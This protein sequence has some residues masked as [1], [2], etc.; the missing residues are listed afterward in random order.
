MSQ[1]KQF[2]WDNDGRLKNDKCAIELNEKESKNIGD[3]QLSGYDSSYQDYTN[4]LND[5]AH[6]QKTYRNQTHNVD[7]ESALFLA[8]SSNP[9]YINQLF[10]RPYVG[11]YCGAGMSSI[12]QKDLESAL[13]QGLLTNL[14]QKPC[15]A[16]RGKSMYRFSH[17]P[18]FGNPQRI[19]HIEEPPVEMGGWSRGGVASRDLIRRIDFAKRCG[20][21]VT[22]QIIHK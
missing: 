4:T 22:N 14:R 2:N 20:N 16:C 10:T 15:E 13:Q 5:R 17:L 1:S 8:E 21:Q 3:Y 19:Q 11:F 9:R 7:D 18:E 12:G 6:F